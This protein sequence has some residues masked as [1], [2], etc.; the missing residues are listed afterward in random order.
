MFPFRI[1]TM[2]TSSLQTRNYFLFRLPISVYVQSGA[3]NDLE[4]VI[5]PL[6]FPHR[7]P[8]GHHC[9]EQNQ[10][11]SISVVK[12]IRLFLWLSY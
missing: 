9:A 4:I 8:P 11:S 5:V 6:S 7:P 10:L 3:C 1:G 2:E 12:A